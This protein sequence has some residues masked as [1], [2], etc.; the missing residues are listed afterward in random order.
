MLIV[1]V[2]EE[3]DTLLERLHLDIHLV[4]PDVRLELREVV[5]RALAVRRGDDMDRVL[6][7]VLRNLAPCGLDGG[8][9]VGQRAVLGWKGALAWGCGMYGRTRT[10]SKRT[11]SAKKMVS[12]PPD[13]VTMMTMLGLVCCLV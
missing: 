6:P 12:R 4:R 1:R 3:E 8:D 9:G 11:A 13:L 2:R 5:H 10:I 7:E